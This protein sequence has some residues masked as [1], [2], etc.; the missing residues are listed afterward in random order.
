MTFQEAPRMWFI[1]PDMQLYLPIPHW[2]IWSRKGIISTDLL[3]FLLFAPRE[4]NFVW[5]ERIPQHSGAK[6]SDTVKHVSQGRQLSFT[7]YKKG[8]T[9]PALTTLGRSTQHHRAKMIQCEVNMRNHLLS[10]RAITAELC[11]ELW[12]SR[13]TSSSVL[14]KLTWR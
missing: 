4:V 10:H 9:T 6:T 8:L 1:G 2:K 13:N 3:S 7:F 14:G 12:S 5:A 11:W